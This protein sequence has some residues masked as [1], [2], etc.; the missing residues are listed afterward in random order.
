MVRF[1]W[2]YALN[3]D[4]PISAVKPDIVALVAVN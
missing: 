4:V 2:P 3:W 1:V